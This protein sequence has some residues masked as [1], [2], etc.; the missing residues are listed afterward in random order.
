MR[1]ED[2]V[3]IVTGGGR[4][5]GQAISHRLV[6][7]GARVAVVDMDAGRGAS[8]AAELT[9]IRP[10]AGHY[11]QCDVSSA[12]DVQRMVAEVVDT[13]GGVDILVNG[14]AITDRGTTVLDLE[15]EVWS[16][17]LAVSLDSVFLCAKYVGRR[18]VAQ[19]RGGVIVN[20][21]STSGHRGRRN[22]TAY[23]AAKGAIITLTRSLAVQLGEHGIRVNAVTPNKVGSPVGEDVEPTDRKRENLLGRGAV[24]SDI[25]DA[26]AFLCSAE[27]GFITA[28]DLVVD[29]GSLYASTAG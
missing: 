6:G 12:A 15:E 22:A 14:V 16:R 25:A 17:V 26:V 7:E 21:G 9:A 4:N 8:V 24:P 13:F 28:A 10:G 3:A 11:V 19:G 27:A 29:G 5:V 2:K 18:L 23:S 1:F 20:I